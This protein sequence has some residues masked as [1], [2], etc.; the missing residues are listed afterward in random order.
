[1]IIDQISQ[2]IM[3]YIDS[4]GLFGISAKLSTSIINA[5]PAI[6]IGLFDLIIAIVVVRIIMKVL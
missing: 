6:V 1:M 3:G 4:I 5:F 2:S